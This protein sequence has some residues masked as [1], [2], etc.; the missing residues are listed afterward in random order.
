MEQMGPREQDYQEWHSGCE[1]TRSVP[2]RC[3]RTHL[4]MCRTKRSQNEAA[5]WCG[6]AG[7]QNTQGIKRQLSPRAPLTVV[8]VHP[9]C[10]KLL[11]LAPRP[12]T[13]PAR[14]PGT[15]RVSFIQVLS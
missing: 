1:H 8:C 12:G 11:S 5:V 14:S 13:E 7:T 15:V 4:A 3:V 10:R 9:Q 6:T 2:R